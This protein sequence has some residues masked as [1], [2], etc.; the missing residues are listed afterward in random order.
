MRFCLVSTQ[1]DWG[2]GEKLLWSLRGSLVAAGH[3]VAWIVRR[4]NPLHLAV[5]QSPDRLLASPTSRGARPSDWWTAY[6]AVRQWAPDVLV[7]NDSHAISLGG[8]ISLLAGPQ[9]PLRIAFKHTVFPLRS[10]LRIRFLS[11]MLVCVS[12]AVQ[13]VAIAGG[14][15]Q[16]QTAVVYGGCEP[17]QV[18]LQ[19]RAWANRTFEIAH[20]EFLIVN[21]GNLLRC[22]GHADLI[23]AVNLLRESDFKP[24]VLIAGE[25]E[26]RQHLEH[27]IRDMDLE[28]QIQLLGFRAD[29]DR[30]L[31]ASDLVVQPSHAEG[32]SLVLIQ[33][34]MLGKPIVA[35]AVGGACEV[36]GTDDRYGDLAW[37]AKPEDP[38]SLAGQIR[39][40]RAD[41][42]SDQNSPAWHRIALARNRALEKFSIAENAAQFVQVVTQLL[43]HHE[44]R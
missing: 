12:R 23:Q 10:G 13:Q 8:T 27:M 4:H 16:S 43:T 20:D 35:T 2:G 31:A 37:I 29:A 39:L 19:A 18:D 7:M 34:Q 36:L 21:V 38:L 44:R 14:V 9:R 40:A 1:P 22:K 11:D 6:I 3:E 30:I 17:P 28:S 33:A 5:V 42:G 25:G 32:L 15:P 41:M 26:Q 24:R